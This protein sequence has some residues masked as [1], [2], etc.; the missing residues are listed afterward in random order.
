MSEFIRKILMR[1]RTADCYQ[2]NT[3]R[4]DS[5]HIRHQIHTTI[6]T[7]FC[8]RL[9]F[10]TLVGHS[11]ATA[12]LSA[13]IRSQPPV[14]EGNNSD[15]ATSSLV[16]EGLYLASK[17]SEERLVKRAL[18]VYNQ[19]FKPHR[20]KAQRSVDA[21]K[22]VK[23]LCASHNQ[24]K[25]EA[26]SSVNVHGSEYNL[27][28][29]RPIKWKYLIAWQYYRDCDANKQLFPLHIDQVEDMIVSIVGAAVSHRDTKVLHGALR[30]FVNMR[31]R[32]NASIHRMVCVTLEGLHDS[33]Y[34]LESPRSSE[35]EDVDPRS[36]TAATVALRS[37]LGI[38][39]QQSL[40]PLPDFKSDRKMIHL[41]VRLV[42]GPVVGLVNPTQEF[43][44]ERAHHE[45]CD[46]TTNYNFQA[47]I[48]SLFDLC[49]RLGG[50]DA[51]RSE[52]FM[53]CVFL[54]L[55]DELHARAGGGNDESRR[56]EGVYSNSSYDGNDQSWDGCYDGDDF[57]DTHSS[58]NKDENLQYESFA[59]NEAA[60]ALA[61]AP[62][63]LDSDSGALPSQSQLQSQ[64][65][66]RLYK[67]S[68][69]ES[70]RTYTD[71]SCTDTD[72]ATHSRSRRQSLTLTEQRHIALLVV[73]LL[74]S[75][76]DEVRYLNKCDK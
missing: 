68:L 48:Q 61:L 6:P 35:G 76:E 27:L 32:P 10:S 2:R 40:I 4:L 74:K 25:I 29:H 67:H 17:T 54:W 44:V 22:I 55:R 1:C 11:D 47:P 59:R 7:V 9:L 38:L 33:N 51:H 24:P 20:D 31:L 12:L 42:L 41:L 3:N 56:R 43:L 23:A 28:S 64:S 60:Q 53:Q 45:H 16:I 36:S 26:S 18:A 73:A 71:T 46:D 49:R 69:D 37:A 8:S 63:R 15:S 52:V 21:A 14:L 70:S 39:S 58:D 62:F 65:Q 30:A 5:H 34:N 57:L 50:D 72:S 66:S 19:V 13:F 75:W